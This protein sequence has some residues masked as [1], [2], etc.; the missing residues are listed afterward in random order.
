MIIVGSY[1][2]AAAAVQTTS[3]HADEA[4]AA[5]TIQYHFRGAVGVSP[6]RDRFV[7]AGQVAIENDFR[8]NAA[9]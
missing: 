4:P 5:P 2:S 1:Y 3:S 7:R 9:E 6:K 8:G